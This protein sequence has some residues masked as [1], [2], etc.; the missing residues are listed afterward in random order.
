MRICFGNPS[1]LATAA[2]FRPLVNCVTMQCE[3]LA[4]ASRLP[5]EVRLNQ[6]VQGVDGDL[7][8]LR[9]DFTVTHEPSITVV[10]VDVTVPFENFFAALEA[11]S[12]EKVQKYQPLADA[13][14]GRGYVVHVDGFVV[15]A[16]G[17][18]HPN[19]DGLARYLRVS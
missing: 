12:V 7:A 13:L 16:L 10:V 5:G 2:R 3:R 18:W 17:A 1:P 11:A 15:G 9:S 8:A 4:A 14:R 6:R 19:N